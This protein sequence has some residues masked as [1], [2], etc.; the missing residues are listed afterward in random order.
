MVKAKVNRYDEWIYIKRI[1]W[2][3]RLPWN[4]FWW[5]GFDHFK[6]S[7]LSFQQIL[8]FACMCRCFTRIR[9]II[10]MEGEAALSD[11][12][13]WRRREL[14]HEFPMWTFIKTDRH[15]R[16]ERS[17]LKNKRLSS[18]HQMWYLPQA[19]YLLIICEIFH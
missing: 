13:S 12:Y 19:F 15:I 17:H 18:R 1:E 4:S 5:K 10:H 14:G 3:K 6:F 7:W 11:V 16:T 8:L 9:G 2:C